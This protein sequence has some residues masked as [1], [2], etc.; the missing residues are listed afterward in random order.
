M[1]AL[2]EDPPEALLSVLALFHRHV[3]GG[4][5]IVHG[6]THIIGLAVKTFIILAIVV[7]LL[8]VLAL[9]LISR[10]FRRRRPAY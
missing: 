5:G 3:G 7:V 4:H 1:L 9:F 8:I 2:L 10:M 6:A